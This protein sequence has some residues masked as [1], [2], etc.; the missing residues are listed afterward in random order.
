MI[1][2]LQ[3]SGLMRFL[4]P[5]L[6]RTAFQRLADYRSKRFSALL[7][8]SGDIGN[9]RVLATRS[10]VACLELSM[11]TVPLA[12]ILGAFLWYPLYLLL[13]VPPVAYLVPEL[14]LK[15]RAAERGAGVARELPFFSI[16]VNVLGSAGVP[17]YTIFEQISN[18]D[19]FRYLHREA[20][21]IKRDV[22]VFGSNPNESFERVASTHPCRKFTTFLYGYTSKVR[23]GGDLPS[24]LE[25]ESG[26]LLRELEESWSRYSDRS[27]VIGSLMITMFGVIPMILL[28]VG[29]FSPT[30]SVIDLTIFAALGVPIFTVMLVYLAGRLQP[31]ADEPLRGNAARSL[32]LAT[33]GV[34]LGALS[35][36]VW[37]GAACSL[38]LFLTSYGMSVR[39]E[40]REAGGMEDALPEFMKDIMEYKRQDYDL[41][42]AIIA[43]SSKNK[44]TPAFDQLLARITAQ[45]KVGTSLGEIEVDP[46]SRLA[47]M[48]LFVLAQMGRSGGGTVETVYQLSNYTTRVV[49]MKRNTRSEMKPYLMISFFSPVMI[50]FG[51]TFLGGVLNSYNSLLRPGLT[52]I[53]AVGLGLGTVPQGLREVSNLLIV[54]SSAALGI[55]SAKMLDLTVRNTLRASTNVLVATG[56]IYLA[57]LINFAALVHV[58]G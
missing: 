4:G 49:E 15:D 33:P 2:W 16:L 58:P 54:V 6:P 46:K 8:S 29:V 10:I 56:V 52:A 21:L 7:S 36:E 26:S 30:A 17:L 28:I 42:K 13:I 25:G 18:S 5:L 22:T 53:N 1:R 43:I 47:R 44:Y 40:R 37:L 45:L 24:Y 3:G 34:A 57:T 11:V 35:R 27:G 14:H 19:I 31:I 48:V 51:V 9:P 41:T 39:G 32:L 38:F 55:I 12:F 20:L 50:A 23:A